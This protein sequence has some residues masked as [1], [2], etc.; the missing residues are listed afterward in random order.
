MTIAEIQK[1][2]LFD[3]RFIESELEQFSV[4]YNLK[5][6]LRWGQDNSERDIL[7]SVA[8][9]IYG[10]HIM[11][12]YFL[13]LHPELDPN[14]VRQLITWHDMAE[15]VV[16]DMTTKTKTADHKL[17][18]LRAERQIVSDAPDHIKSNLQDVFSSFEKLNT[19]EARFVK[20][21]DKLEPI[22]HWYFLHTTSGIDRSK[23]VTENSGWFC[24]EYKEHRKQYI[25]EFDL[26]WRF[27]DILTKITFT[28]GCYKDSPC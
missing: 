4:Y 22:F 11:A 16:D 6:T 14:T 24:D 20:A 3:D 9:H 5:H 8:E 21:L 7:E 27:D 12:D 10:M 19:S 13:P 15:A 26:V 18:E 2:I 25:Q 23:F 28:A 17:N 1:R